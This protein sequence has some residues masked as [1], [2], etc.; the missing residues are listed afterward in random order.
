MPTSNPALATPPNICT[1][2]EQAK[3]RRLEDKSEDWPLRGLTAPCSRSPVGQWGMGGAL[4]RGWRGQ[5]PEGREGW[6]M[7]R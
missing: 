2:K 6:G 4:V 7:D 3:E 5:G 1:R